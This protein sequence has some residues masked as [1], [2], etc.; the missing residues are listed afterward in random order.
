VWTVHRWLGLASGAVVFVVALTGA[1]YAFAPE[2]NE[3]YLHRHAR[4]RSPAGV[5]PMPASALV[6]RAEAAAERAAGP[7][8]PGTRRWLALSAAPDRS[9]V[10]TVAPAGSSA[11]Y[12]VYVD[13]HRGQV[14]LVRDMRWDPLGVILRAHQTLLLPAEIGR[15]VVGIAVLLFVPSLVTGLVLWFPRRPGDLRRAGALRRRLTVDPRRRL[16]RVNYDLHRIL[17]VYALLA[18]LTLALTGLVWSFSWVDRAVYWIATG[19]GTPPA[20]V[21]WR[22]DGIV[23]AAGAA[24]AVDRALDAAGRAFPGADRL[25][26]ALPAGPTG[27]L[28]V[29]ATPMAGLSYRTDC[30][31]FDGSKGRQIGAER[32]RDQNAGDRLRAMNH[33]VHVGRIA[34]VPGRLVAFAASLVAASLPVTGTLI[35][36]NRRRVAPA[37]DR[38]SRLLTGRDPLS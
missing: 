13:R 38:Q 37:P 27:G 16:P 14:L 19:G 2:I 28:S 5:P 36:W 8:A 34:G 11:W 9:A 22:S 17:G 1:M 24:A 21:P 29:C 4:V 7:L 18:A 26:A 23:T 35:W 3:L 12:E 10:Y 31:W 33:D 30:L 20:A 6:A 15:W 32:Y 25:D